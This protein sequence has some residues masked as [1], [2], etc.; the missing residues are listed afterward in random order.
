ME[1]EERKIEM[2]SKLPIIHRR[3]NTACSHT[4]MS[5][6]AGKFSS[7]GRYTQFHSC[8]SRFLKDSQHPPLYSACEWGGLMKGFLTL[9]RNT[10]YF[11][12]EHELFLNWCP[13][14]MW[15]CPMHWR[16]VIIPKSQI[17][18]TSFSKYDSIKCP[19][20]T[21]PKALQLK[22]LIPHFFSLQEEIYIKM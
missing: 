7:T 21:F 6:L 4:I 13:I 10:E 11:K 22:I 1:N 12:T 14:Y 16:T 3:K 2:D 15:N 9:A 8:L 18:I 17:T 19:L 20:P 5:Y